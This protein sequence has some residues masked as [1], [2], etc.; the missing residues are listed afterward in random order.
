MPAM[1]REEKLPSIRDFP[2][3]SHVQT[4]SQTGANRDVL[5]GAMRR[6]THCARAGGLGGANARAG[7]NE[8]DSG[9]CRGMTAAIRLARDPDISCPSPRL[10]AAVSDSKMYIEFQARFQTTISPEMRRR[11]EQTN[12]KLGWV[13]IASRAA[14]ITS[15]I[16]AARGVRRPPSTCVV[17][18]I[19]Y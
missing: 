2:R 8:V 1:R 10:T 19:S 7:T 11:R 9:H 6:A 14:C 18:K 15:E 3:E 13:P 12:R 5:M 16:E 17:H 4:W